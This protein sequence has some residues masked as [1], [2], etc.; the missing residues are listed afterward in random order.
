MY[1]GTTAAPTTALPTTALPTTALSPTAARL[2]NNAAESVVP[3][4]PAHSPGTRLVA[5]WLFNTVTNF[6]H[7]V[8]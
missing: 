8:F 1:P 6:Y 3:A 5:H 7:R 2:Q 4:A